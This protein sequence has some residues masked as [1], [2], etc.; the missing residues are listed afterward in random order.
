MWTVPMNSTTLV[1]FISFLFKI[2]RKRC[3]NDDARDG[4]DVE[5][6]LDDDGGTNG[7]GGISCI[8]LIILR[9]EGLP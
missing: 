8:A 5:S 2:W 1:L 3:Q 6:L 9:V 4:G 7:N